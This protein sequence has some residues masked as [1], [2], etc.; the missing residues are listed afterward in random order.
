M[1]GTTMDATPTRSSGEDHHNRI[2][3]CLGRTN[4]SAQIHFGATAT[5]SD[6][7]NE[8]ALWEMRGRIGLRVLWGKRDGLRAPR[9]APLHWA[10]TISPRF[11]LFVSSVETQS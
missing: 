11:E 3:S 4:T 6:A 2:L 9:G 7:S 1:V 5:S 8:R 10:N